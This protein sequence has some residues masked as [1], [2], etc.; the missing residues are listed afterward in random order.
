MRKFLKW[1]FWHIV[2]F[3]GPA[4]NFADH[5]KQVKRLRFDSPFYKFKSAIYHNDGMNE[6]T[7]YLKDERS[8]TSQGHTINN[9]HL[10][11]SIETGEIVGFDIHDEELLKLEILNKGK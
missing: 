2:Y 3:C 6:W 11:F 8:F 9:V 7:A 1:I 10:M 5:L 4:V